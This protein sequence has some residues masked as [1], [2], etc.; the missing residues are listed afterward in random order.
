MTSH[1]PPLLIIGSYSDSFDL[2]SLLRSDEIPSNIILN[3]DKYT[4]FDRFEIIS[5]GMAFELE[6]FSQN[7]TSGL[8]RQNCVSTLFSS[9][10][11]PDAKS[12]GL[13]LSENIKSGRH[14]TTINRV[15]LRIARQLGELVAASHI[16][17]L[18]AQHSIDFDHF[19]EAVDDYLDDGPTPVLIQIAINKKEGNVL[20]T[21]G[22]SYFANQ[23]ISLLIPPRLGES[24][25]IKRLVRI[26]HDVSING[27]IDGK[28]ETA[29]VFENE[30]IIFEPSAD[31]SQLAVTIDVTLD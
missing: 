2:H 23:E 3:E 31:L 21:K 12:I 17:W 9:P 27:K 13:W 25:S 24:E 26:C 16:G 28:L 4:G 5:E 30:R 29:G 7:E 15:L 8:L 14:L 1:L 22:L 20:E 18:P 10:A 6:L 11:E 19:K